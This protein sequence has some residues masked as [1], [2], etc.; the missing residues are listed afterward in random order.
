M[1]GKKKGLW[2]RYDEINGACGGCE[3]TICLGM[4]LAVLFSG[5]MLLVFGTKFL[6]QADHGL[7]TGYFDATCSAV[8]NAG[9]NKDYCIRVKNSC[10]GYSKCCDYPLTIRPAEPYNASGMTADP[11]F[12]A[13]ILSRA[14]DAADPCALF[15]SSLTYNS[16]WGPTLFPCKF[17]P[18]KMKAKP[19][20]P[21]YCLEKA[22]DPDYFGPC[23]IVTDREFGILVKTDQNRQQNKP[24]YY[25]L[26]RGGV[27]CLVLGGIACMCPCVLYV[28]PSRSRAAATKNNGE[29][30]FISKE[31]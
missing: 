28:K 31:P 30:P 23:A 16:T 22:T 17:S 25:S 7:S 19:Y 9:V 6:D 29:Q 1:E 11:P 5:I 3:V 27:S 21:V 8:P 13:S 14:C 10:S 26:I 4:A 15:R 18:E 2:E 20:D 12:N 24:F